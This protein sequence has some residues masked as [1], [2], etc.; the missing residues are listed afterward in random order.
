MAA[1]P[2]AKLRALIT[3]HRRVSSYVAIALGVLIVSIAGGAAARRRI[4]PVEIQR[5]RLRSTE[6][7]IRTFRSAFR[8]ASL[9][10]KAFRFADSLAVSVPRDARFSVAQRLAQRAEQLGLSDVRVRFVAT[11]SAEAP[12]GPAVPG[13][14]EISG[15]HIAVADY[16]IAVDCRGA[17]TTLLSLVNSLPASVAL[18]RLGAD[19]APIGGAVEYHLALAVFESSPDT[20]VTRPAVG[21]VEQVAQLL[22]YAGAARDSDL[23]VVSAVDLPVVRD[24]FA[25]RSLAR[26]VAAAPLESAASATSAETPKLPVPVYRVT[27]TLMAGT[28]RAALIN[29]RLI[30]VGESLPDGSKLTMVER[31]R[32]VVTDH[33]GVAHSVAVAREGDS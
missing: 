29:D 1:I 17:L 25:P 32:V 31:D 19:R 3:R 12:A 24:P 5:N 33:S 11:D 16:A 7:D 23:V 14:P 8:Q 22:P 15:A 13:V 26:V 18:Q 27:T 6:H 9:E 2:I 28:R 30:Y 10:E 4:A 21:D 20:T